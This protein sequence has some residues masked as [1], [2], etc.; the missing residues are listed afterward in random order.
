MTGALAAP[1]HD[2][3][4]GYDVFGLRPQTLARAVAVGRVLYERY[5]R[6]S[7]HGIEHIPASG[8]TIVIANHGGIIPVDAAMLCLDLLVRT[9]PPRIPRAL[10]DHFVASLPI[11]S[12][13]FARVGVVMGT[14]GNARRLLERGELLAIWPEGVSG[15]AKPFSHRYELQ[16]WRT[17]FAELALRYHAKVV[18]AAIVGAEESWPVFAKLPLRVLHI[19]YLPIPATP[20]PLPAHFHIRYGAPLELAGDPDD[21]HDVEKAALVAQIAVEDVLAQALRERTSVWR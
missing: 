5:F 6:V 18:P 12:T 1:F 15:P 21:P 20:L 9:D 19:P 16:A 2:E 4:H 14:R 13:L 7:S 8:P 11:A 17:G 10:A 3:G